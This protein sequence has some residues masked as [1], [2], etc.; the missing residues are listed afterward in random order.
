MLSFKNNSAKEESS[1]SAITPEIS[2]NKTLS[3]PSP[4]TVVSSIGSFSLKR[5][6]TFAETKMQE[7]KEIRINIRL[8]NVQ[9]V[10][11][12]EFFLNLFIA[13]NPFLRE[14]L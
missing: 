10:R 8:K 1:M 7:E 3:L 5:G 13:L 11:F 12:F 9:K 6:P 4:E 14:I 2:I